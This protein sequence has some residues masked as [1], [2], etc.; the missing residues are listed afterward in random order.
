MKK[1]RLRSLGREFTDNAIIEVAQG[2]SPKEITNISEDTKKEI[3][4]LYCDLY[5][6]A[7]S[8][9]IA[10]Q[11][12]LA[13]L[14]P[15][16]LLERFAYRKRNAANSKEFVRIKG[17]KGQLDHDEAARKNMKEENDLVGFKCLHYSVTESNGHV[18][19]TIV[20]KMIN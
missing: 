16:K 5:E 4:Q 9:E 3:R 14:Q 1:D 12:L 11:D 10:V 6:V 19:I 8:K 13:A 2:L 18:E 17:A 20:K 7:D 15:E